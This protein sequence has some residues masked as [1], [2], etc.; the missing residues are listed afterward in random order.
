MERC[1]IFAGGKPEQFVPGN[2][3]T[4]NAFIIA[5]DKGY[6]NCKKLGL[7]PDLTLGDFDSLG[8]IPEGTDYLQFPA[9]KDDTD[10]MLAVKEAIKRGYSDI[11]ILGATGGRMDHMFGN[12][13]ALA[14]IRSRGAWGRIV[15]AYEEITV[16]SP[17][18]YT[19]SY[20]EGFSLSLF[21]YGDLVEGLTIKGAKYP[22]TDIKLSGLFPLGVCNEITEDKAVVSFE[23]GMLL[24]IRSK[25]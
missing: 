10:L 7:V 1:I 17:G 4:N 24:V 2:V 3:E 8:Y 12:I 20:R 16:L 6:K 11:T 13:Q 25:M 21:S 14:Y 15:S 9:H 22:V 5:A 19:F 23:K 18:E